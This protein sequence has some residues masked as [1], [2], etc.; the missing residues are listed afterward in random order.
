[1]AHQ[2]HLTC[3]QIII[4]IATPLATLA[5]VVIAL[6][7]DAILYRFWPPQLRIVPWLELKGVRVPQVHGIINGKPQ[8]IGPGR[9]YP[10]AV[11]ND[12]KWRTPA[13][14]Q[15]FLVGV[16]RLDSDSG[17]YM[18]QKLASPLPFFWAPARKASDMQIV[19]RPTVF[20]FVAL[21]KNTDHVEPCVRYPT[22]D[23]P[24]V[25][26]VRGGQTV[27]YELEVVAEG[28]VSQASYIA[29]VFWDGDWEDGD[30]A[31]AKHLTI[32]ERDSL[33]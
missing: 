19:L 6:F 11:D 31:M 14:C 13:K 24:A 20:D 33:T 10:L 32:T 29:E 12:R 1:M 27:R 17:I 2:A 28:Y 9:W 23:F 4:A 15:V 22:N 25:G 16:S 5:L 21:L 26:F 30:E 8:N 18:K 3:T 7:K